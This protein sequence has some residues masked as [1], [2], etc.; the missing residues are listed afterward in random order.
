MKYKSML[1]LFFMVLNAINVCYQFNEKEFLNIDVQRT[2]MSIFG[3]VKCFNLSKLFEWDNM[4]TTE[5]AAKCSSTLSDIC[6]IVISNNKI[7]NKIKSECLQCTCSVPGF[8]EYT[9][10][11]DDYGYHWMAKSVGRYAFA[12]YTG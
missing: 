1:S 4:S 12:G 3:R 8:D 9:V 7:A 10:S 2:D 5:C 6:K 11:P